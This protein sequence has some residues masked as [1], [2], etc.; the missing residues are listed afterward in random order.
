[1]PQSIEIKTSEIAQICS[2]S[3]TAQV[4]TQGIGRTP[5]EAEEEATT[6]H[7]KL[8]S[9]DAK[10]KA[11]VPRKKGS[12]ALP[13]DPPTEGK[14]ATALES[15]KPE[16][17]GKLSIPLVGQKPEESA[18]KP[19]P[20]QRRP[21][22]RPSKP[23]SIA[24]ALAGKEVGEG[25][26]EAEGREEGFTVHAGSGGSEPAVVPEHAKGKRERKG[27]ASRQT[28][29]V[30][31]SKLDVSGGSGIPGQTS[32]SKP[33]A[34][35]GAKFPE[36]T[37]PTKSD[38]PPPLVGNGAAVAEEGLVASEAIAEV[39]APQLISYKQL[40]RAAEEGHA[41]GGGAPDPDSEGA[42]VL[43]LSLMR[44]AEDSRIRDQALALYVSS[45][46]LY[47][48]PPHPSP[49]LGSHPPAAILSLDNS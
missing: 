1:M 36:Q 45:K 19:A 2:Q 43:K 26:A 7:G 24:K 6:E 14:A 13:S 5:G 42:R 12:A 21:R 3:I 34:V 48:P 28:E 4:S 16:Q 37:P 33:D 27:E 32:P 18:K 11:T 25:S 35:T 46:V 29:K 17:P 30:K 8:K 9:R 22:G 38:P 47:P 31:A 15:K 20:K 39:E 49:Q 44:F 23:E 40:K 41:G 10:P